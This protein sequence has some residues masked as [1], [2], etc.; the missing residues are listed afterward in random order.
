MLARLSGW[1][2]RAEI[3]NELPRFPIH[4]RD[5]Q[6]FLPARP[7]YHVPRQIVRRTDGKTVT[8]LA[9][10]P[11]PSAGR[12]SCPAPSGNSS[13]SPDERLTLTA[14]K[15]QTVDTRVK[16]T[17]RCIYEIISAC[18]ES[19]HHLLGPFTGRQSSDRCVGTVFRR[20]WLHYP[21]ILAFL[22]GQAPSFVFETLSA[23]R[24][25][26]IQAYHREVPVFQ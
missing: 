9:L 24:F 11:G 18:S 15:M 16:R 25:V 7:S 5:Y 12:P 8:H 21:I 23:Q 19:T 3:A 26:T 13:S 6:F 22:N 14:P 2:E 10:F 1:R 4:D 20:R 17:V